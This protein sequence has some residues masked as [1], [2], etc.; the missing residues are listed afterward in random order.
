MKM[1]VNEIEYLTAL[2]TCLLAG[3]EQELSQ[4]VSPGPTHGKGDGQRGEPRF[5]DHWREA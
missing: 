5:E 4:G 1:R 3:L 2:S